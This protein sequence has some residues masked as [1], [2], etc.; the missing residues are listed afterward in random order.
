MI[1]REP[2]GA[3]QQSTAMDLLYGAPELSTDDFPVLDPVHNLATHIQGARARREYADDSRRSRAGASPYWGEERIWDSRAIA[4]NPML[5]RSGRVWYT[6]RIRAA[7][8]PA[9]CKQGSSH[10]SA[11][12]F[13]LDTSERQLAVYEPKSGKYTFVDTCFSTHHLQFAEDAQRYALDQRRPRGGRLARHQEIRSDRRCGG[14]SGLGAVRARHQ[15]QRQARFVDRTRPAR[16]PHSRS[17]P[18]GRFLCGHAESRRRQRLG[19]GRVSLSR[20]HYSVR[21][22]NPAQRDLQRARARL[23]RARRG[24]RSQ[25]RGLGVLRE[26]TSGGVRP[27]QMQGSAQ[28][29][30]ARPAIIVPK[31]GAS[32]ACRGRDS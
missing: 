20:R 9:F 11:K 12:A 13:P 29:S 30:D 26:R 5:D 19:L 6:A 16:G 32:I 15:R 4:H 10:P 2:I 22:A 14:L 21:S 1:S 3:I 27:A 28:R 25:R 17:A 24:H 23:R 31:A 8:N 7:D 18:G